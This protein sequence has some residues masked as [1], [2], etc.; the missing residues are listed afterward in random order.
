M[1]SIYHLKTWSWAVS[2]ILEWREEHNLMGWCGQDE[3]SSVATKLFRFASLI[4]I[5]MQGP[6]EDAVIPPGQ[7]FRSHWVLSHFLHRVFNEHTESVSNPVARE[8]CPVFRGLRRSN[9]RIKK[10]R[11]K[12]VQVTCKSHHAFLL[13]TQSR[14]PA[15]GLL[16]YFHLFS[17][18]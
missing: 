3:N 4:P 8:L 14:N 6:K 1:F 9:K 7:N 17:Q 12:N 18:L 15:Q 5:P 13:T 16:S 2:K 10:S 11:N